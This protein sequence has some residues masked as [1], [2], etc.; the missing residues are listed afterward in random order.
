MRVDS[1]LKAWLKVQAWEADNHK[2]KVEV[3]GSVG[4]SSY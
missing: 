3:T 4:G 2:V 1:G